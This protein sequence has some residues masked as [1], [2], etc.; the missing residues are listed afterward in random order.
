MGTYNNEVVVSREKPVATV[1]VPVLVD[2]ENL[3]DLA[4]IIQDGP[5]ELEANVDSISTSSEQAKVNVSFTGNGASKA[6]I[7]RLLNK[8][9]LRYITGRPTT[10]RDD[11]EG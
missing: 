9:D 7:T 8:T 11:E 6:D 3:A 4:Q 5:D 1:T 10:K 2:L